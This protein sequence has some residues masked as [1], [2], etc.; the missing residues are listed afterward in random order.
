[1]KEFLF[2]SFV[3][4]FSLLSL[5]ALADDGKVCPVEGGS[6]QAKVTNTPTSKTTSN[7][8][9]YEYEVTIVLMN[10]SPNFVNAT[11]QVRETKGEKV[12]ASDRVLVLPQKESNPITVKVKTKSNKS[13]FV[14]DVVGADCKETNVEL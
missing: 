8:S 12:L 11:Y 7:S 1:M 3:A 9:V 4:F 14:V 2:A 13:T 10:S 6:V 5:S